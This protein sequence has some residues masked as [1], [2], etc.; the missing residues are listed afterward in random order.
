MRKVLFVHFWSHISNAAGSVEKV[1]V[2]LCENTD[3][4]ESHI[5]CRTKNSRWAKITY[6]QIPVYEFP[7]DRTR[8]FIFNKIAGLGVFT[9]PALLEIINR[10]KPDIVHFH[11]RQELVD[12]I[13]KKCRHKFK[14]VVHY[15]RRFEH[16]VIPSRANLLL[17]P[18]KAGIGYIQQFNSYNIPAKVLYNPVPDGIIAR[19]N[20]PSPHNT[21][22]QIIY[23]GGALPDKGI[24]E[25][26]AAL[27]FNREIFNL[28]LYGHGLDKL[29]FTDPRIQIHHAV[30]S[31]IFLDAMQQADI[32]I[33]PSR[34]EFFGLLAL[35]AISFGKL[36]ICSQ[37]DGL[38]E[39]TDD[40]VAF[41]VPFPCSPEVIAAKISEAIAL[42]KQPEKLAIK[43]NAAKAMARR[44]SKQNIIAQLHSYYDALYKETSS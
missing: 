19:Q 9:Y 42:L 44:F 14:V 23:G 37:V 20:M 1:I 35:E 15:H 17:A 2:G 39:F 6:Q 16:P 22:P 27:A 34:K 18:S 38:A 33:M 12:R 41:T 21:I 29:R 13:I 25:L 32:V 8:N 10:L 36:L 26:L 40:E 5:A 11:N 4:Y 28:S 24:D 31:D 7:E 3:Y 43:Q 30:S